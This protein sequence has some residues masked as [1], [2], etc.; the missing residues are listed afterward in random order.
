MF[1]TNQDW[2][3]ASLITS[4]IVTLV[5][6][7]F[8]LST[9]APCCT[10]VL[11]TLI[12]S[13]FVSV[14][15]VIL[16]LDSFILTLVIFSESLSSLELELEDSSV[17]ESSELSL[18]SLSSSLSWSLSSSESSSTLLILLVMASMPS[19]LS[20]SSCCSLIVRIAAYSSSSSSRET[21][22][23]VIP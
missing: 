23:F 12:T 7:F 5:S 11:A 4:F 13:A 9:V 6:S 1:G 3:W 10:V 18:S 22:D 14:T 2:S 19:L 16:D 8:A 20:S 15:S 21:S 17:L